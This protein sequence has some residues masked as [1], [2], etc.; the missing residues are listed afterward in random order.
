VSTPM[1]V[2]AHAAGHPP[3]WGVVRH[4]QVDLE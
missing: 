1:P 2:R 4:L 3:G